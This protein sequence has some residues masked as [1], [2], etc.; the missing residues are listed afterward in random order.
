MT[1]HV[2]AKVRQVV[3]ARLEHDDTAA[4]SHEVGKIQCHVADVATDVNHEVTVSD[5]RR[6][7]THRVVFPPLS[8]VPVPRCRKECRVNRSRV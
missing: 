8:E 2:R 6:E 4:R 5:D 3:R 1:L 7:Q